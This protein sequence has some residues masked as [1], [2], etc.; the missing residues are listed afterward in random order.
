[1]PSHSNQIEVTINA[2][3]CSIINMKLDRAVIIVP[4]ECDPAYG[5]VALRAAQPQLLP[6]GATMSL[7]GG[8]SADGNPHHHG[9][10]VQKLMWIA[11]RFCQHRTA[12]KITSAAMIALFEDLQA[13]TASAI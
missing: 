5:V 9:C 10:V 6:L 12:E 13:R 8:D 7:I 2:Q 3:L 11:G 4:L 1:M